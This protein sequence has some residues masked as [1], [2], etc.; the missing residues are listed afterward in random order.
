MSNSL[1]I[2]QLDNNSVTVPIGRTVFTNTKKQNSKPVQAA[3]TGDEMLAP[4][5]QLI[6][7]PGYDGEQAYRSNV[8]D[9]YFDKPLDRESRQIA[10]CSF[11]NDKGLFTI[12]RKNGE[13]LTASSFLRQIDFG[14]GAQG[15]RGDS[16]K[17]Q[18]D[19]V[20]GREGTDGVTGCAGPNGAE[21]R[22]GHQGDFGIEGPV[23]PQGMFGPL[24]PTGPRGDRGVAGPPGFEGKRGLCGPSCPTTSQGPCGPVGMT[25]LKEVSLLPHPP[26]EALIWAA[27][28]DCVCPIRPNEVYPEYVR[29]PVI[30]A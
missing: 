19:G 27:A 28:E 7:A 9:V 25:M 26:Q 16:G 30:F 15:A 10:E 18:E 2:A 14:V 4:S 21:G 5:Y 24:G 22:P 6:E 1:T 29:K 8:D 11:D 12:I 20:D 13:V 23:G 17:D 3:Q